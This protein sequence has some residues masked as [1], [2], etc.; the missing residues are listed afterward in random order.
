[1]PLCGGL[2]AAKPAAPEGS[3]VADS[4]KSELESKSGK[5]FSHYEVIE[6]KTQVVA[7]T[8]YFIKIHVGGEEYIHARVYKALP[9]AQE[10]LTLSSFQESKTKEEEIVHF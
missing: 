3:G 8:N 2:G 5:N 10:K 6:F 7:G 1:M 9:H 4:V